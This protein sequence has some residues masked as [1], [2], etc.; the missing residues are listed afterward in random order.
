MPQPILQQRANLNNDQVGVKRE[1]G[2]L[3]FCPGCIS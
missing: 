1:I 2:Y 3:I